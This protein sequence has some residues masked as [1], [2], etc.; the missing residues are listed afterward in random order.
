M[1]LVWRLAPR[2]R[3]GVGRRAVIACGGLRGFLVVVVFEGGCLSGGLLDG[4]GLSCVE[5]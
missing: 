4:V 5:N 3:E 2:R 1:G